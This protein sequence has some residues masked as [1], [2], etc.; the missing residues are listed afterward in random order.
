LVH[1]FCPWSLIQEIAVIDQ[2]MKARVEQVLDGFSGELGRL[3]SVRRDWY[4]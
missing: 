3:V 1:E 2:A 4:Y